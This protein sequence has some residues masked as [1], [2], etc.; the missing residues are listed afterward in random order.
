MGKSE[1]SQR[2][3]D[4]Q[5]QG[6]KTNALS[7]PIATQATTADEKS[8]VDPT[9]GSSNLTQEVGVILR[10]IIVALYTITEYSWL[11]TEDYT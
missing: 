5:Y 1:F 7:K 6:S 2:T 9:V 11:Q 4:T 3:M 10:A 8:I